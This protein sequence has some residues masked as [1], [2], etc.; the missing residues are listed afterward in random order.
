MCFFA[1]GVRFSEQGFG[2]GMHFFPRRFAK[3]PSHCSPVASQLNSSL[4]TIA[5][6]AILLPA[7][8]HYNV[9]V[10]TDSDSP[11]DILK[12]SHGVAIILLF[13]VFFLYSVFYDTK[14]FFFQSTP[15]TSSSNY[16][17]MPPYITMRPISSNLPNTHLG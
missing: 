12:V 6:I 15:P 2:L 14:F 13:S 8:F 7:A 9:T 10:Q 4:L 11:Q 16:T 5:V 1:G 17:R 3:L